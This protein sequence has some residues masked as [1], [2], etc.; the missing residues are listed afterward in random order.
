VKAYSI[1]AIAAV[2]GVAGIYAANKLAVPT[3]VATAPPV[4]PDIKAKAKQIDYESLAREPRKHV[5]NPVVLEGRVVEAREK[6]ANVILRVNVTS[7]GY[8]AWK[9]TVWVNYRK[10]SIN[11]TRILQ[12]DIVR[13]WG[14]FDWHPIL[15]GG[16]GIHGSNSTG[17]CKRRRVRRCDAGQARQRP[18]QLIARRPE[19]KTPPAIA[20]DPRSCP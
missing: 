11:E 13:F 20:Q 12:S 7:A 10:K 5:G 15:P 19:L 1:A 18:N 8:N 6:D 3:A 14:R 2:L 17:D 9:D 4:D 16:R